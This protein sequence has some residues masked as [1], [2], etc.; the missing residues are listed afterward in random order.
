MGRADKDKKTSRDLSSKRKK[1]VILHLSE[2]SD[3]MTEDTEK[4]EV[5]KAFFILA[6]TA[7]TGPQQSQVPETSEE[8][9]EQ[10]RLA[11]R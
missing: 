3:L 10:G 1:N 9:L 5:L 8:S 4:A 7:E 6:S 2:A 11:F